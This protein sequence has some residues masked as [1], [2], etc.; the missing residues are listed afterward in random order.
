LPWDSVFR[1][2]LVGALPP[3]SP[4]LLMIAPLLLTAAWRDGRARRALVLAGAYSLI[5]PIH[6]RYLLLALPPLVVIAARE[7]VRWV[8]AR[9]PAI[10]R[11]TAT[12]AVVLLATPGA[13]WLAL[14]VR[15]LGPLPVSEE[16]RD[17]FWTAHVP[18]WPAVRFVNRIAGSRGSV[19][20]MNA[21]QMN[22]YS[23]GSLFGDHL[24]E[25]PFS[26]AGQLA[27]RPSALRLSLETIDADYL[28]WPRGTSV[29]T[30]STEWSRSFERLYSD[31]SAEV[32]RVRPRPE[33]EA[34]P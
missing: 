33:S 22:A 25:L 24:G 2:Q 31:P 27:R 6:A 17:R 11:A 14:Q 10:R 30:S 4:F 13:A 34:R 18:F 32:F 1:R 21:E 26:R 8:R 5:V 7:S 23:V 19:Y 16:G 12:A 3:F 28:L 29:D 20:A 15:R 9:H